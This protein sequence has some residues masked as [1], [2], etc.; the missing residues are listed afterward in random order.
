[1]WVFLQVTFCLKPQV[2]VWKV[3][4]HNQALT[5]YKTMILVSEKRW[6]IETHNTT[7]LSDSW[8]SFT[9]FPEPLELRSPPIPI[10]PAPCSNWE[11]SRRFWEPQTSCF[12]HQPRT[13]SKLPFLSHICV[14][15][16]PTSFNFHVYFTVYFKNMRCHLLTR[17]TFQ[18]IYIL[19]KNSTGSFL[20]YTY[21]N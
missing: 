1:M 19:N 12:W 2:Q 17:R 21:H 4:S 15:C 20:F 8:N 16:L 6:Q 3:S 14:S 10:L 7:G 18:L 9:Q 13:I 11:D 5:F